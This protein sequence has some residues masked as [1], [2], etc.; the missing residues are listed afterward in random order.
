MS[1]EVEDRLVEV[2][3]HPTTCPHGNPIPGSNCPD[4][5]LV[6]LAGAKP[7]DQVL[8]QQIT[9]QV[10]IDLDSLTYLSVHGFTP[11]VS[12]HVRARAPDGTLTLDLPVGE[13]AV[14]PALAEQMFVSEAR[15]RQSRS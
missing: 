5:K 6:A 15:G 2:L 7:G 13:I 9:E 10:E 8:L 11:G 3:G 4:R 12:A 14:G 1:D